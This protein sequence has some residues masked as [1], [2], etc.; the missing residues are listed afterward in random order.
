MLLKIFDFTVL[1]ML[2]CVGICKQNAYIFLGWINVSH[3]FPDFEVHA[4]NIFENVATP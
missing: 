3:I 4:V 1:K 2:G